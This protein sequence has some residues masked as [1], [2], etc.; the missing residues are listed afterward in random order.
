M[1]RNGD[2]VFTS[3]SPDLYWDGSFQQ[4]THYVEDGIYTWRLLF[5]FEDEKGT[6]G[7]EQFGHILIIR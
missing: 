5:T 1:D 2:V 7:E 6:K 4:G 3:Q